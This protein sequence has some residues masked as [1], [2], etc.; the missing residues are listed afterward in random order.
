MPRRTGASPLLCLTLLLGAAPLAAQ[1]PTSLPT[2][3]AAPSARATPEGVTGLY[4]GAIRAGKWDDA[5][6]LMH[7]AALHQ[8][9]AMFEPIVRADTSGELGRQLFGVANAAA[10]AALSDTALFAHF[11][12]TVI[13]ASPEL[14]QIMTS[15]DVR[16]IGHVNDGPDSAYVVYRI[17]V[18]LGGIG[19][20]K[21]DTAPTERFGS[22]WRMLLT[23]DVENMAAGLRARFG[24]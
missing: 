19:I 24:T 17:H 12:R 13:G 16:M 21:V 18:S 6:A 4:L 1:R 8:L 9:R 22:E 10:L 7:P 3:T 23:G 2:T 15:A 14:A 11:L 5:A 20:G